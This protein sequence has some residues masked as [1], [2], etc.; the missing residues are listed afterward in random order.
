MNTR[1]QQPDTGN[2]NHVG[3]SA[4]SP[5]VTNIDPLTN[6]VRKEYEALQ[7]FAHILLKE[8]DAILSFSLSDIEQINS[9]KR[10]IIN[11]ITSIKKER[12]AIMQSA[13]MN[14]SLQDDMCRHLTRATKQTIQEIRTSLRRNA[15]L[16][17]LS[18]DHV[19]SAMECIIKAINRAQPTYGKQMKLKPILFSRRV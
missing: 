11:R 17:S 4:E 7:E 9:A 18:A 3:R 1:I 14:K 16:L 8:K 2:N 13:D 19:K 5:V 15:K 12:A 10:D 6:L